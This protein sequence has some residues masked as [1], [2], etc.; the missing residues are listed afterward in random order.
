MTTSAADLFGAAVAIDGSLSR[1]N[2]TIVP[3]LFAL[4]G[5]SLVYADEQLPLPYHPRRLLV[6]FSPGTSKSA[7]RNAHVALGARELREY[8]RLDALILVKVPNGQV[9][10]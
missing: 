2:L 4:T 5:G 1:A 7:R 6:R 10:Q 3:L 8:N 9:Q